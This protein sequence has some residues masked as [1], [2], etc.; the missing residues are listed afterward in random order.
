MLS[1]GHPRD[2]QAGFSLPE[3]LIVMLL[4]GVV[5]VIA[6]RGVIQG[7]QTTDTA[8][9]RVQ[10]MSELQRA[11]QRVSRELRM[12]CTVETATA[13]QAVVD[14]LRDETRYRFDFQVDASG[15]LVADVDEVAD[16]GTTTDV[17][18]EYIAED[19]TNGAALFSYT[20]SDGGSPATPGDVRNA[21]I[22]LERATGDDT[23]TWSADLHLR[24]G[25]QSCGF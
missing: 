4:I 18:V 12:A 20:D 2:G 19:I 10:A 21:T 1:Q 24:N 3:L 23:L 7:M 17:R 11:G 14:I 16:D 15:T 22:V 9:E 5:G 6:M 13:D 25:G 8:D